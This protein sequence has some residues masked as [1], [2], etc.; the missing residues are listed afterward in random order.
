M[1]ATGT[2]LILGV[3][4]YLFVIGGVCW[5]LF[6]RIAARRAN[7]LILSSAGVVAVLPNGS[8][9]RFDWSEPGLKTV[10]TQW[11]T[12]VTQPLSIQLSTSHKRAFGSI[13]PSGLELVESEARRNNLSVE[14]TVNGKPPRVW[15]VVEIQVR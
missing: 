2:Y 11:S 14:S 5:I 8:S 10:I 7:R 1:G 6:G 4:V 13:D 9:V 3:A 12:D 15:T